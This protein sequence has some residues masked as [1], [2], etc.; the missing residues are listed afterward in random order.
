MLLLSSNSPMATIEDNLR[1]LPPQSIEAEES[2]LGGVLLDNT[3]LDRAIEFV[4]ADDFYREAHRKIMRA[5][6]E[7]NQRGEPVD[8]VTLSDALKTRGEHRRHRRRHLPG[9][10]GRQGANRRQRRL[11]RAHRAAEGDPAQPDSNG[12]RDRH[13]GLRS[14][15]RRRRV[16]RP[17][18]AQDLRDLRA[19]G[20]A[21]LLPHPRHHGRLD[22]GHR[23]ALRAQ[24][25]GD[26]RADRLRRS[27]SH[28]RRPAAVG[29]DH[30]R[31]PAEHGQDRLRPQHRA[32]RR[33][34]SRRPASRSSRWKCRRSS[35]CC[36]C[37]APRRASISRRCAPAS[38][39][40]ATFRSWRWPPAVCRTRR[41][42][43]TT[44]R[45]SA[46]SSCAPRRAA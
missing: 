10:A 2:V 22:E 41:S 37:C 25:A 26:R 21:D 14:D 4:T 11:L 43:S 15:R 44:R 13:A 8:L 23:A 5:M 18:G 29:P 3:A 27:R 38:P 45:R 36:A 20:A 6:I 33:P 17:G 24:G 39:R 16:P 19:Q 46:C 12:D 31:R 35:W 30:H 7:L 9:R 32:V 1:K 40:S 28:D 42:T 34:R